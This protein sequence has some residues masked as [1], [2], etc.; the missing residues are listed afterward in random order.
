M[1]LSYFNS[2]ILCFIITYNM[3]CF[4]VRLYFAYLQPFSYCTIGSVVQRISGNQ[5]QNNSTA[6]K[7]DAPEKGLVPNIIEK[8]FLPSLI[9]QVCKTLLF[10]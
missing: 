3:K 7:I 4:Y 2:L 5:Q 1:R 10:I 9:S 8:T 6:T